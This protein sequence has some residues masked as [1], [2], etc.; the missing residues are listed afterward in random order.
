VTNS[1]NDKNIDKTNSLP[2][3][4]KTSSS[5]K[6]EPLTTPPKR[7]V[8][9]A[10]EQISLNETIYIKSR[11]DFLEEIDLLS[12][13]DEKNLNLGSKYHKKRR[14][15]NFGLKSKFFL[16]NKVGEK[17]LSID[18][19]QKNCTVGFF[20]V[21]GLK[22]RILQEI[23]F[24]SDIDCLNPLKDLT[25]DKDNLSEAE[26]EAIITSR[27]KSLNQLERQIE[28]C[29]LEIKE[30]WD[31]SVVIVSPELL[32]S[33]SLTLPFNSNREISQVVKSETQDLVVLELDDFHLD[34]GIRGTLG[35][36]NSD[37][38]V[39]SDVRVNLVKTDFL[40]L[41]ISTLGNYSVYPKIVTTPANLLPV[42]FEKWYFNQ[43]FEADYR[44]E[45][46]SFGLFYL[47]D[48]WLCLS[49]YAQNSYRVEKLF[50]YSKY[51]ANSDS[52]PRITLDQN[53]F[54]RLLIEV[55]RTIAAAEERYSAA[56][57]TIFCN[58]KFIDIVQ[59]TKLGDRD[60]K[61]I[62]AQNNSA[63]W[64]STAAILVQE[65][66]PI[67]INNNLRSGPFSYNPSFNY[68]LQ[69]LSSCLS[70]G[71][72]FLASLL[73]GLGLT[74][75]YRGHRLDLYNN[76]ISSYLTKVAGELEAPSGMELEALKAATA[77]LQ[78]EIKALTPDSTNSPL[79]ALGLL[80]NGF[81]KIENV[82]LNRINVES[83][84]ISIRGTA[85]DLSSI[86]RIWRELRNK[87]TL[88]RVKKEGSNKTG[89]DQFSF[90]ISMELCK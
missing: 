12:P 64:V 1:G 82:S 52:R 57:K 74:Y 13:D 31:Y 77:R 88:C 18:L 89:T 59:D 34:Y 40:K 90:E 7:T 47:G 48:E 46:Q 71:F 38:K 75:W 81:P 76:T 83:N 42:L 62:G 14:F 16:A 10:P 60:L 51:V 2:G 43:G 29:L 66:P 67:K 78:K 11:K 79:E 36:A 86:D 37:S 20:I 39:L 70:Y 5:S 80:I 85:T 33:L 61:S 53:I 9:K 68:L 24:Q 21:N 4:K 27:T 23:E 44:D 63:I 17:I 50:R 28:K 26:I 32:L 8:I 35:S 45:Y 49:L 41:L 30:N 69:G 54:N 3:S 65:S 6:G 73:L 25:T 87:K 72:A 19:S 15:K 55:E 84:L 58:Q 22:V 56:F